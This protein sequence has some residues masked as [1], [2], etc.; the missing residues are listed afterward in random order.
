MKSLRRQHGVAMLELAICL[1]LLITLV[2]GITEFGRAIFLYDTLAKSARD[3]ARFLAVRDPSSP[4][5]VSDAK[6]MAVYGNPNCAGSPLAAGLTTAM[7]SVCYAADPSCAANF[8]S[9]GASPVINLVGVTIGGA[10]TPY[11]FTSVIPSVVPSFNFGAISVTMR[12][13]L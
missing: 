1:P 5:A 7:V 6:C 3:A 9:Q 11:A 13:V 10:N 4:G 2:F 12:Q 8:Q